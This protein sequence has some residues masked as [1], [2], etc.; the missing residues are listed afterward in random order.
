MP[1][2]PSKWGNRPIHQ[3]RPLK[4]PWKKSIKMTSLVKCRSNFYKNWKPFQRLSQHLLLMSCNNSW[5]WC[6]VFQ[7]EAGGWKCHR[8]SWN[9]QIDP[10][11][12]ITTSS[13]KWVRTGAPKTAFDVLLL[14][15][16]QACPSIILKTR[17]ISMAILVKCDAPFILCDLTEI[18]FGNVLGADNRWL[19][20]ACQ[21]TRCRTS[22]CHCASCRF[23]SAWFVTC[24]DISEDFKVEFPAYY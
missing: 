12:K 10:R 1:V 7:V 9:L 17:G 24:W 19:V 20:N 11:T 22:C 2:Q 21:V 5:V 14:K 23:W 6:P 16:V 4:R 15:T 18:H 3:Y 8:R 13:W